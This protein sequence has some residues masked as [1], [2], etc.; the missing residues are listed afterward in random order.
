MNAVIVPL[1]GS[2]LSERAIQPAT[3]L[4]S[5]FGA[6]LHLIHVLAGPAFSGLAPTRQLRDRTSA[7][8]YLDDLADQLPAGLQVCASVLEGEPVERILQLT[9]AR[10]D[11]IIVMCTRGRNALGR[12]AFGS[13]ADRV[14]REATVPVVLI[15]ISEAAQHSA[16]RTVIVPLD[17]SKLAEAV[18]PLATDV[19]AST[20]AML[21]LVRVVD[22][23]A[24]PA[25]LLDVGDPDIW[26][27][28]AE[29]ARELEEQALG[30]ARAYLE[31]TAE[32]L[33][34]A[35]SNTS[36]EVRTGRPANELTRAAET[37]PAP[38]IMLATH[39]RG[40]LRRWALGSVTT[41]VVR[42]GRA[43]VL[44]LPPALTLPQEQP[45]R[46]AGCDVFIPR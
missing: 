10:A 43:P 35:H 42:R 15:G 33:R 39:G 29:L 41:E 37:S 27:R 19:A 45:S 11:A 44:V 25:H 32:R 38:L 4:A 6:E 21:A 26:Y 14:M 9:R 31:R 22:Q 1:D 46:A 20:G 36:W 16:I 3:A 18:L 28:S 40:G 8:Q 23:P 13:V 12:L 7:R 17:G 34:R 5:A 24:E 2:A 30:D